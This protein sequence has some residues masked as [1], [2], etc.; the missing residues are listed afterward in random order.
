VQRRPS[1]K[2]ARADDGDAKRRSLLDGGYR[3]EHDRRFQEI[4]T[5]Q[6]VFSHPGR[7]YGR[8]PFSSRP[9]DQHDGTDRD[10]IAV[11]ELDWLLDPHGT[12]KR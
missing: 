12:E 1:A 8:A 5:G 11:F 3:G 10:P 6:H 4:T 7:G 9:E 2:R